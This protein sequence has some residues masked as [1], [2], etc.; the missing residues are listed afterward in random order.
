[1][2]R[3]GWNEYWRKSWGFVR[4]TALTVLLAGSAGCI[5]IPHPYP[6]QE[7]TLIDSEQVSFIEAGMTHRDEIQETIGTPDYLRNEGSRWVYLMK[8]RQSGGV[9][10]CG[11]DVHSCTDKSDKKI[12]TYL[13]ITFDDDGVVSTHHTA[14]SKNNEIPT[15]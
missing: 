6:A 11:G 8:F 13:V 1:M 9:Q 12:R 4:A 14:S 2:S 7:I 5:A 10:W 15:D 3:H